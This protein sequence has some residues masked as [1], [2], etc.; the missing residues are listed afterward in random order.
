MG[1]WSVRQGVAVTGKHYSST[2]MTPI[3]HQGTN[4]NRGVR[5]NVVSQN[6]F[7]ETL[8][9]SLYLSLSLSRHHRPCSSLSFSSTTPSVP[10]FC[11]VLLSA[12]HLQRQNPH[13]ARQLLQLHPPLLLSSICSSRFPAAPLDPSLLPGHSRASPP[14]PHLPLSKRKVDLHTFLQA[15]KQLTHTHTLTKVRTCHL[16]F[17]CFFFYSYLS[18]L[19]SLPF[20]IFL[21]SRVDLTLTCSPSSSP[22]PLLFVHSVARPLQSGRRTT[23][24]RS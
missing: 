12:A 7:Q 6:V 9:L 24:I 15:R 21:F 11:A 2:P 13:V 14:L 23:T 1:W 3:T 18:T 22:S 17:L 20:F 10:A 19:F 4:H 8:S 16:T 5:G